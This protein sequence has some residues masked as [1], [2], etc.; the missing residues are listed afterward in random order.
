MDFTYDKKYVL[1]TSFRRDGS[2]RFDDGNRWGNFYSYGIAYNLHNEGFFN[3]NNFLASSSINKF[4]LKFSRGQV[5]NQDIGLYEYVEK[6]PLRSR[7]RWIQDGER[8]SFA[9]APDLVDENNT[10]ETVSDM[11]FGFGNL[12]LLGRGYL[13]HLL[14]L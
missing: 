14:I 11:N 3:I 13:P 10:W 9:R 7:L 5:G 1:N 4:K 6:I 12:R 8:P 2:S